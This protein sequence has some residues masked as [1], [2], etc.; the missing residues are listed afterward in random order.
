M[1]LLS[2]FMFLICPHILLEFYIYIYIYIFVF[3]IY[4][5]KVEITEEDLWRL[6]II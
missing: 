4:F 5:W 1:P 3:Y 2:G 6:K